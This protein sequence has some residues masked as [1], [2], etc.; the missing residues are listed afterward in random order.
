MELSQLRTLVAVRDHHS[1]TAAAAALH[2]TQGAVSHAIKSLE[3]E[4]GCQ[5]IL[6]GGGAQPT[7][8]GEHLLVHARA[9]LGR[10]ETAFEEL[11][12]LNNLEAGRLRVGS[13]SSASARLLPQLL[14][15]FRSAYPRVEVTLQEGSDV[16]SEAWLND[17]EVD[18]AFVVLPQEG[19]DVM[20]LATDE[21]KLVTR[22]D[23]K[24]GKRK[25]IKFSDLADTPIILS[26]GG[27]ATLVRRAFD[28]SGVDLVEGGITKE[29]WTAIAMVEGKLGETL[30][31]ELA[32]PPLSDTLTTVTVQ[33]TIQRW[34][35]LAIRR[36]EP[37]SPPVQAFLDLSQQSAP[38]HVVSLKSIKRAG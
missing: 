28:A 38:R 12:A 24:F 1:F 17:G 16:Q 34:L 30:M 27:C 23:S 15:A 2:V 25:S 19:L 35:A 26:T 22:R 32:I 31:P 11:R 33:P 10:L 13:F 7:D 8:A 36:G 18:V 21:L 3:R 5:L 29:A 37:V 14:A 6:R 20:E 4:V 9:V